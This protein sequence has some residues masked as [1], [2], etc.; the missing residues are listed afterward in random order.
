MAADV[1][2]KLSKFTRLVPILRQENSVHFTP[3]TFKVHFNTTSHHLRVGLQSGLRFSR[4]STEP[5]MNFSSTRTVY[6]PRSSDPPVLEHTCKYPVNSTRHEALHY[7]VSSR[8]PSLLP[9]RYQIS[10]S[11][12][13]SRSVSAFFFFQCRKQFHTHTKHA[14][15]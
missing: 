8:P 14:K 3:S 7:A 15:L 6:M 4:V 13:D 12:P 11:A 10:S 9:L 1:S 2:L 5:C